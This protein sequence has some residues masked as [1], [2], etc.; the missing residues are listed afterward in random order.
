MRDLPF[1]FLLCSERSGSNL[2]TRLM[3]SHPEVCAP[4]PKHLINPLARNVFRYGPLD[5]APN[6]SCL[7]QDVE[8]LLSVPFAKWRAHF[9]KADLHQF[10][11]PGDVGMLVRR[12]FE[13]EA[14]LACKQMLF[15][16]EN[17][18]YEFVSFLL[19]EFPQARYLYLVRDP[20][21][22]ALSWKSSA[23]HAGGVVR[24]ARQWRQDQVE[25]LKHYWVL[26]RLQ[27]AMCIR[28]EDLIS[29]SESCLR[30]ICEFLQIDYHPI[31]HEF[32]RDALAQE[33]V[34]GMPAWKN[35]SV[36]VLQNNK[37]KYVHG[38]TTFEVGVIEKICG[39]EM[40]IFGYTTVSTPELLASIDGS[41]IE[42]L[43]DEE[44]RIHV[45][46]QPERIRQNMEAKKA[47]Y[48]HGEPLDMATRS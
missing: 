35:L 30:K 12:I 39:L 28:Y 14:R 16:K 23:A 1:N 42:S 34:E 3:D 26:Q 6:W 7:L 38:L 44:S 48:Q 10:A 46:K 11:T 31:M 25:T 37:N 9:T 20:R 19:T 29:D 8:H 17:H 32:H 2:I 5:H 45:A 4:F 24:A 40:H 18:V 47:F 41:I 36:Q 13:Q 22:M 33:N 21:D 15:I 27:Q 43:A